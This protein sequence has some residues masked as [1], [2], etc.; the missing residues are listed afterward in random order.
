MGLRPQGDENAFCP[1]PLSHGSAALTL[2][3]LDRTYPDFLPRC[4]GQGRCAPFF[5]E[6]R[7]MF[8]NATHSYRKSGG[9]QWRDLC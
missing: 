8:A 3:H 2:C 7:M 1:R 4:T 5:E 6:R 9:A